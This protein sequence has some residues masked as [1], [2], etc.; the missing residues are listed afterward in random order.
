MAE[1]VQSSEARGLGCEGRTFRRY[2]MIDRP[3]IQWG[4]TTAE[5]RIQQQQIARLSVGED[6][7]PRDRA[8]A[9]GIARYC[10]P[11]RRPHRCRDL[12]E[13]PWLADRRR[14][15][16]QGGAGDEH[17]IR[18]NEE[19]YK[20][21][22]LRPRVLRSDTPVELGQQLFGK[23]LPAPVMLAPA[24]YQRLM[25]PTGEL[26][27]MEGAIRHGVPFILSSNGT[28]SIEEIMALPG[29]RCWFQLY[30]QGDR[31]FT[32]DSLHPPQRGNRKQQRHCRGSPGQCRHD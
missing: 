25:H 24:A 23:V 10:K 26:G 9:G 6:L 5:R 31:G 3:L 32:H 18:A 20:R 11:S 17:S 21:I 4:V 22:F 2:R 12:P 7:L 30:V 16:G 1:C 19:S 8:E 29:A 14:E 27:S 28:T 13:R 15:R